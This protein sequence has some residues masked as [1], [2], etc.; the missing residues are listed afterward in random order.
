M[1]LPMERSLRAPEHAPRIIVGS[2]TA[3]AAI[4]VGFAA[5][6]ALFGYG[7]CSTNG[8]AL[9]TDCMPPGWS[10]TAVRLALAATMVAGFPII[11]YP[12]TEVVE[13]V[14]LPLKPG[15]RVPPGARAAELGAMIDTPYA[16]L[17]TDD[18]VTSAGGASVA[19]ED[20]G[21]AL[22]AEDDD[23]VGAAPEREEETGDAAG[24][25]PRCGRGAVARV[26]IRVGEVLVCCVVALGVPNF[27]L[28]SRVVGAFLVTIVGFII[29]PLLH[30][31]SLKFLRQGASGVS[32]VAGAGA[33]AGAAK[34]SVWSWLAPRSAGDALVLLLDAAIF[35]FGVVQCSLGTSFALADIFVRP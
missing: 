29:P 34:R 23:D 25:P 26:S 21:E 30:V 10:T 35:I 4:A 31:A 20:G 18:D 7:S 12:V 24:A 1:A 19:E 2:L 32:D 11:L 14:L 17:V 5:V 9:V 8:G 15:R 6:A 13:A 3:Y 27:S 33:A 28:F 16:T 22:D